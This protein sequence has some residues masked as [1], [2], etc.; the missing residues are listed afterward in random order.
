MNKLKFIFLA[1]FL[2]SCSDINSNEVVVQKDKLLVNGDLY[3][4]KG[5]GLSSCAG[6]KNQ[7]E[8]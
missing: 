3:Y 4:M 8:F 2:V 6:W 5:G 1:L 7:K